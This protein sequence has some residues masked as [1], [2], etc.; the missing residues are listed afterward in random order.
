M[1]KALGEKALATSQVVAEWALKAG[2]EL[3]R[4]AVSKG[5]DASAYWGAKGQ[6]AFLQSLPV[7]MDR[8]DAACLSAMR[9]TGAAASTAADI[10]GQSLGDLLGTIKEPDAGE[11]SSCLSDSGDDEGSDQEAD[12]APNPAAAMTFEPKAGAMALQ[13]RAVHAGAVNGALRGGL[14]ARHSAPW[15]PRW[16]PA[17]WPAQAAAAPVRPG[18]PAPAAPHAAATAVAP[19]AGLP[20]RRSHVP[21]AGTFGLAGAPPPPLS[22]PGGPRWPPQLV[23]AGC[24][25]HP[26]RHVRTVG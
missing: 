4:E 11:A 17:Q 5:H 13:A 25:V 16:L 23:P 12:A 2:V 15:S 18:A 3:G 6:E 8:A 10:L 7:V 24:V 1:S 21:R 19:A 26:P 9:A 22:V 20:Q 14:G